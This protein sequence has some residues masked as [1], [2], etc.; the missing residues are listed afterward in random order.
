[1][2]EKM[3]KLYGR[4]GNKVALHVIPGHFAT[5]HSHINFYID[6]TSLKTRVNEAEQVAQVIAAD[7]AKNTTVV[8]TIV[9][10]DGT[11]MIG[12][13]L[14]KEFEKRGFYNRNLH[15]TIYVVTPEYNSNNQIIFR[16]NN[17]MAIE[18]KNVI[19]LL[20]TTTTGLT[21]RRAAECI[22][23]YGGTLQGISSIF[24]TVKSVDGMKVHSVFTEEDVPGYAAYTREE[25]PYC[26]QGRRIEA[27]VNGFGYSALM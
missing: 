4:S 24:S 10:M 6:I 22:N 3:M 14:A 12:A 18:G 7:Y 1:M 19:L 2:K 27:M 26:R 11:E 15:D 20:A 9:C 16:D 23:Y 25:C 5:S 8:D 13:F 21:I 17:M